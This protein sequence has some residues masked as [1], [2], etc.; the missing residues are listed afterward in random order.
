MM[1]QQTGF[2]AEQLA[3]HYLV[4][5]GLSWITSNYRCR[6]GEIDLIMAEKH[7]LVF[8]EV[9]LRTSGAFGGAIA[10]VTQAKQQKLIKTAMHYM[11]IHKLYNKRSARFDVIGIQ[12]ESAPFEW[13]KNA[14]GGDC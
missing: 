3:R 6:W 11:M 9:R 5:Q 7:Y 2:A 1:S 10:S 13:I 4:K 12:G 14:F 8:V